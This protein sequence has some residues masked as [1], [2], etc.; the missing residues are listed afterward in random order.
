MKIAILIVLLWSFLAAAIPPAVNG[1]SSLEV[2]THS[3]VK[4]RCFFEKHLEPLINEV[5]EFAYVAIKA[6]SAEYAGI[7]H[8]NMTAIH[9][10]ALLNPSY[11]NYSDHSWNA[12]FYGRV[13]KRPPLSRKKLNAMTNKFLIGTTVQQLPVDQADRAREMTKEVLVVAEDKQDVTVQMESPSMNPSM[14][15]KTSRTG[16][17]DFVAKVQ[18][19]ELQPGTLPDMGI[20]RFNFKTRDHWEGYATTYFVPTR[21]ITV[22]SDIDDVLRDMQIWKPNML[23]MKSFALPHIPW[24]NMPSLY[25]DWAH[26]VPG[27]HFHYLTTSPQPLSRRINTFLDAYYPHGSLDTRPV[28]WDSA[29]KMLHT[30]MF[31]LE[32]MFETFPE[33]KFVLVGDTSNL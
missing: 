25:K 33:R 27:I 17:Y 11:A 13:Y 12:R 29:R 2:R 3:T 24:L 32:K 15:G 30:R 9:T 28:D 18:H 31:Y 10:V 14:S 16:E 22:I 23:L 4:F 19:P 8:R 5:L 21:G 20:Q 6:V 7:H 1:S 26:L